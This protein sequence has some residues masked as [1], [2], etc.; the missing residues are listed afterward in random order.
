[1]TAAEAMGPPAMIH[2][3][4]GSIYYGELVERVEKKGDEHVTILL[5]T[6]A[7]KRIALGDV[8]PSPV[9]LPTMPRETHAAPTMTVRTLNGSAFHGELVERVVNEHVVLK[10]ETGTVKTI[11]WREI[12]E[13]APP[14]V[15]VA[16][17]EPAP[18]ENFRT[19]NGSFYHGEV[20]EKVVR[21]HVTIKIQTGEIKTLDWQDLAF[22]SRPAARPPTPPEIVLLASA[23]DD[24]AFLERR[25]YD[26]VF[27][28]VC[29]PPC[30]ETASRGVYRFAG[31]NLVPT[32]P[33]HPAPSERVVVAT[34]AS[35]P[36]RR[37]AVALTIDSAPLLAVGLTAAIADLATPWW[38]DHTSYDATVAV[39]HIVG[40]V[41]L[42]LGLAL[43]AAT[44]STVTIDGVKF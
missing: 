40:G 29:K 14:P 22:D 27:E 6:G 36:L 44:H 32:R 23:D 28:T 26:G 38:Q 2:A 7:R 10:L 12:D 5:A 11:E 1:M 9:S 8:D 33:F 30:T 15:R 25:N 17:R 4:D 3:K 21:D 43:L 34:M 13:L 24:R 31:E 35:L 16:P 37:A 18:V 41:A 39:T 19:K 20:I 42:A